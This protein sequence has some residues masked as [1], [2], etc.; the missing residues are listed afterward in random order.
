MRTRPR[1]FHSLFFTSS[2][3]GAP[4]RSTADNVTAARQKVGPPSILGANPGSYF[5][6][7]VPNLQRM[8]RVQWHDQPLREWPV[9]PA[10]VSARR[11]LDRRSNST[12]RVACLKDIQWYKQHFR[13]VSKMISMLLRHS[14]DE[15]FRNLRR[16]RIQG[17]IALIDFPPDRCDE[18]QLSDF[19]SCFLVGPGSLHGEE[20]L[21][22][23]HCQGHQQP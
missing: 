19:M 2:M 21:H 6:R 4:T 13:K 3:P 5:L 23:R 8:G 20:A 17:D 10:E 15:Q 9:F 14:N 16:N 1:G 11:I 12:H 18:A 7:S 22:L